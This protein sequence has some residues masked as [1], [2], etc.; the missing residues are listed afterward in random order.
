[1]SVKLNVCVEI[2]ANIIY[3]IHLF[4]FLKWKMDFGSAD[5]S[6]T[7]ETSTEDR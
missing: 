3:V 2:T 7:N 4:C 1:M 5:H 6:K